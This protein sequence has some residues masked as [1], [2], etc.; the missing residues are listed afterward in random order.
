MVKRG[1]LTT[2]PLHRVSSVQRVG[3]FHCLQSIVIVPAILY[4]QRT[5]GC[6]SRVFQNGMLQNFYKFSTGGQLFI[7][8]CKCLV[9]VSGLPWGLLGSGL[10]RGRGRC[11][12]SVFW[13]WDLVDVVQ[14]HQRENHA[15][16][17]YD[18]AVHV[19]VFRLIWCRLMI[20][21]ALSINEWMKN[22]EFLFKCTLT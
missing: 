18:K 1:F 12:D 17:K 14:S 11:R 2:V 10:L 19:D 9:P 21:T 8:L 20:Q 15:A 16:G 7:H 13:L 5:I 3:S 22:G 4:S 6:H